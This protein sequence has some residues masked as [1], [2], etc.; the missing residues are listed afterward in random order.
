MNKGNPPRVRGDQGFTLIELLVVI[1]IIGILAAIA[2]PSFLSQTSKGND[3]CAKS[4]ASTMHKAMA[5][6]VMHQNALTYAGVTVASLTAFE[7]SI[8]TNG[9]GSG[10]TVS[11]GRDGS[12]GS[13][14]GTADAT[15]YCVRATSASGNTFAIG[16]AATGVV[17]RICTRVQTKG[18]CRGTTTTGS[19]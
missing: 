15:R 8:R 12:A 19:W 18:G 4:M 14:T 7:G 11:I 16:R 13:C 2:V 1:L 17:T 6:H 9:C 3:A 10:T 5:G